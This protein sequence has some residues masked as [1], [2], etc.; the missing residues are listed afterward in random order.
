VTAS[1]ARTSLAT[2]RAAPAHDPARAL[3]LIHDHAGSSPET[4]T[5]VW[6][7]ARQVLWRNASGTYVAD[8]VTGFSVRYELSDG[9]QADGAE[10]APG[11]W[12]EVRQV[13]ASV[14]AGVGPERV[15]LQTR[16][17]VGS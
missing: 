13:C 1:A 6:D 14:S 5:V 9:R 16:T 4:V 10:L 11:E 3:V 7:P 12:P 2:E 15:T 17:Q 8:H